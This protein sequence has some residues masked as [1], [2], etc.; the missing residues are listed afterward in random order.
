[1]AE[2]EEYEYRLCWMLHCFRRQ[3]HKSY[4]LQSSVLPHVN[5]VCVN[6]LFRDSLFVNCINYFRSLLIFQNRTLE[7]QD[8]P[9]ILPGLHNLKM[10]AVSPSRCSVFMRLL[11]G[12][13]GRE[14]TLTE[15]LPT[16]RTPVFLL[17]SLELCVLSFTAYFYGG[18]F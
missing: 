10:F 14:L 17:F 9:K 18:L 8:P 1:M 5:L 13:S 11:C 4:L 2:G 12:S 15:A 7:R 3:T 16:P 6:Y